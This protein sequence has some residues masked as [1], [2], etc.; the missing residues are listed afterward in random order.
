M[1]CESLNFI[2]SVYLSKWT[3]P[4][5]SPPNGLGPIAGFAPL[6]G[7][8]FIESSNNPQICRQSFPQYVPKRGVFGG[9]LVF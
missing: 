8:V 6:L 9:C 7:R 2:Q 3:K 5:G 1:P 4:K